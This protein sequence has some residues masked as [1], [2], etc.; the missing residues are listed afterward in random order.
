MK[1]YKVLM[2]QSAAED[3]QGITDYIANE[4][5]EPAIAKK[6]VG[7]IREAVMSLAELPTRHALVADER[8]AVQRIR[9]T[10]VDNYII[11]YALSEKAATVTVIRI[12]YGRRD[13]ESILQDM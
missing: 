4:L 9:K 12:L 6:L 11:F 2:T 5:R 10:V 13:W 8:L 7:R 3:L 1:Q